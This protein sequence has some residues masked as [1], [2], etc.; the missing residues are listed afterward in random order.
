MK[1]ITIVCLLSIMQLR[2]L[3]QDFEIHTNGLIYNELTMQQLSHIAD[4]LNQIYRTFDTKPHYQAAVKARIIK[5]S[6]W[7]NK[8]KIAA[9]YEALNR[10]MPIS[11]FQ[12]KYP[13]AT[14]EESQPVW[15]RSYYNEQKTIP[16][17]QFFKRSPYDSSINNT[18]ETAKHTTIRA[19]TQQWLLGQEASEMSDSD[20]YVDFVKVLSQ[21]Q[22]QPIPVDYARMIQYSD[23]LIDTTAGMFLTDKRF[24]GFDKKTA[25]SLDF[26]A[27][28][29][30]EALYKNV[31]I[32][33]HTLDY[34]ERWKLNIAGDSD[35]DGYSDSDSDF[36]LEWSESNYGWS[37]FY[38][39]WP[40]FYLKG[41]YDSVEYAQIL[42]NFFSGI[43]A[44]PD[45]NE[46]KGRAL[47][48][49]MNSPVL[50]AGFGDLL[51]ALGDKAGELL[52]RRHYQLNLR[53]SYDKGPWEHDEHIA[54]LAAET[55]NW[56]AF[57]KAHL[58]ILNYC[59][60]CDYYGLYT[61]N[62]GRQTYVAELE[63]MGLDVPSL[64]I[65]SCLYYENPA[66]FHHFDEPRQAGIALSECRDSARVE[67]TLLTMIRDPNLDDLNRLICYDIFSNYL[68]QKAEK[69]QEQI[70][71]KL[72]EEAAKTLPE[73]LQEVINR[74]K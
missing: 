25:D 41:S 46:I 30:F 62:D 64:L 49:C 52:M 24:Y 47:S 33:P 70:L 37:D 15:M 38:S 29:E 61:P 56:S 57:L 4:S 50:A 21:E 22:H 23:F 44:L 16:V 42:A 59:M 7:M 48:A 1:K 17:I 9:A 18:A 20:F 51:A 27:V 69:P 31:P 71:L 55:A 72:R 40:D 32:L 28:K 13:K 19:T 68:W 60:S 43:K 58:T 36:Y 34:W 26:E 73:Y 67:L 11:E 10:G 65:G 8:P 53:C 12:K 45:Y 6:M 5:I 66:R 74:K 2:A 54:M 35:G 14:I 63:A 39:R 3:A